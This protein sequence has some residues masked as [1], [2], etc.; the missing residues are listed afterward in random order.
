MAGRC[1]VVIGYLNPKLGT[2][3]RTRS[4]SMLRDASANA[5]SDIGMLDPP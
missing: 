2:R 4:T 1:F 5:I 3:V